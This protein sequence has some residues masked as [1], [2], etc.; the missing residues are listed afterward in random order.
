M[1]DGAGERGR[2]WLR[3]TLKVLLG[4]ISFFI[5]LASIGRIYE[6]VAQHQVVAACPMTGVRVDVG[7]YQL[8]LNCTGR[9][10]PT[11]ILESGATGFVAPMEQGP[12][13]D[14]AHHER[15]FV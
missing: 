9:G 5:V 8:F 7:G 2:V 12:A 15:L 4:L 14:R 6:V 1:A 13:G 10:S 3:R 11:V